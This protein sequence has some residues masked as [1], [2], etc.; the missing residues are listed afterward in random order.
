MTV[1]LRAALLTFAIGFFVVG[2]L[3]L[4][5]F[6]SV[7]YLDE[8]PLALAYIG[9]SGSVS[10]F[11]LMFRAKSGLGRVSLKTVLDGR[12][13][14]LAAFGIY[15]AAAASIV[16]LGVRLGVPNRPG[17]PLWAVASLGAAVALSLGNFFLTLVLVVHRLIG[18]GMRVIAWTA[19]A[20]SLGVAVATGV[21]VA[22]RLPALVHEC[23][24]NPLLLVASYI[25]LA[26]EMSPLFLSFLLFG[27]VYLVAERNVANS[28]QSHRTRG[29]WRCHPITTVG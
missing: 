6:F 21:A 9:M 11:Y 20:W 28:G 16:L 17:M 1:S 7:R 25:P 24:T 2:A 19:F 8:T 5:R 18:R 27:V 22:E 4:F 13:S 29:P 14:L 12:Q 26:F 3:D 10:G 23:F 15:V